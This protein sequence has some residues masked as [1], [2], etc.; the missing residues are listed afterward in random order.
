VLGLE[1]TA[2][3]RLTQ[4]YWARAPALTQ[5]LPARLKL[6][7]V[8]A[9]ASTVPEKSDP[10]QVFLGLRSPKMSLPTPPCQHAPVEK[11]EGNGANTDENLVVVGDRPFDF[12]QVVGHRQA[13]HIR[14][15]KLPFIDSLERQRCDRIR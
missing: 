13:S 14:V 15:T 8:P 6:G 10:G 11:S 7:H 12:L 2:P 9:N 1:T 4:M 5:K 3:L